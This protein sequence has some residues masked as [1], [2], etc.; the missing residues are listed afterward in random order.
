MKTVYNKLV[1]V[2][3]KDDIANLIKSVKSD[4]RILDFECVKKRPEDLLLGNIDILLDWMLAHWGAKSNANNTVFDLSKDGTV[5]TYSFNT[6]ESTPYRAIQLLSYR[7][8]KVMFRLH[9]TIPA[10]HLEKEYEIH[11]GEIM[12]QV[13]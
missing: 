6:K 3:N 10:D 11:D 4:Q 8:P 9:Y 1:V 7:Y 12:Y 2:G 5:G 13:S